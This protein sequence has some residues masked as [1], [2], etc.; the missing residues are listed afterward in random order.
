MS[1]YVQYRIRDLDNDKIEAYEFISK[2]AKDKCYYVAM[3]GEANPKII[4][5]GVYQPLNIL[6]L[7]ESSFKRELCTWIYDVNGK[8]IYEGDIV[9]L[10]LS[11]KKN[12]KKTVE[13]EVIYDIY[14]GLKLYCWESAEFYD[15][16]CEYVY[17]IIDRKKH[18]C[19][20]SGGLHS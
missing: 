3:D 13:C 18:T 14:S 17:E 7:N 4:K 16:K 5:E 2:Y 9:K 12:K 20:K 11:G 19:R 15:F 1:E 6:G 8:M 10:Y